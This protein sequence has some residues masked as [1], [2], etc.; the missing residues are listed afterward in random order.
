MI[1]RVIGPD[2]AAARRA[3]VFSA[4]LLVAG[5]PA[6]AM[7]PRSSAWFVV[8][9][10]ILV[11]VKTSHAA[12]RGLPS[13]EVHP[14]KVVLKQAIIDDITLFRNDVAVFAILLL[15]HGP[16]L[17]AFGEPPPLSP[18]ALALGPRRQDTVFPRG[19]ELTI[20]ELEQLMTRWLAGKLS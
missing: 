2:L 8:A 20:P 16:T 6:I 13:I 15:K 17:V 12:R 19:L 14:E 1:R 10:A 3:R 5:L 7:W 11:L 9:V 18:G 4:L